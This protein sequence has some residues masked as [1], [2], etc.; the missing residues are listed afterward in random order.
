MGHFR[1]KR[2]RRPSQQRRPTR[3]RPV[4]GPEPRAVEAPVPR[5]HRAAKPLLAGIGKPEPTPF[6]PDPFQT[7]ALQKIS[8]S[9]VLVS[10]PTG[11]G[12]TWIALEAID[13]YLSK[14][15]RAWYATPLKALSN[16][17]YEEFGTR[18][19]PDQVGILTGDRKENPDAP[20]IVG[21]TEILRNQ[22]YDA[23]HAGQDLE[24]DLIILDEAHFLG[25]PD[26]GVVWEEVLIYT[27]SRVRLLLLSATISNADAVARWLTH[28]R[29]CPCEVVLSE[30]R[31]VPLRVLFH[32]PSGELTPFLRGGR[33]FP[34]AADLAKI[35]KKRRNSSAQPLDMNGLVT[36]MREFNLLP[37]IIFLKSRADCD[38][39]L[40]LLQPPPPGPEN[41]G[42]LEAINSVTD[43]YPELQSRPQ[44]D[45]LLARRAGSHHAGQLPAWRLLVEKM[46]SLGYLEVIFSTSTVAAGVNFPARTVVVTQSDRFDGR[47]FVDMTATD[48]HQMTGRAGR[49]GMDNVGFTLVVPGKFMDAELIKR[50]L[51]SSPEPLRSRITV[52][53]SMT[54]NLL[55][56]HKPREVTGLLRKSFAAFHSNP[57]Q[58]RKTQKRLQQEFQ[59]HLILLEELDYL[60]ENGTA[61]YDGQWAAKLRLDHP[62]LIAELI[63]DGAFDDLSPDELAAVIAPFVI[64][65]DRQVYTSR[66]V[67]DVTRPLWKIFRKMIRKLKPLAAF[68]VSRGFDVPPIMFWPAAAAFIW[69]Q[70]V[71]WDYLTEHVGADEGDMAMLILRTIDH[72]RQLV[73]LR[74]EKPQLAYTAEHAMDMLARSPLI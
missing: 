57:A 16:S 6:T 17:K 5:V 41:G 53:F 63:R 32:T 27:P 39:A 49:R 33:V 22:L 31:P 52:N 20:L 73:S 18:Y 24:V 64:D 74:E 10:A 47:S 43:I 25:D 42:F 55:L 45:L 15:A 67:W 13:Q 19:G 1:P 68:L 11:S 62:L 38:K 34:K 54:L 46:M 72:L 35:E 66:V 48:L 8:D 7:E 60:D 69:A 58:A 14:A 36:T 37:A 26:R 9:D 4:A 28:I 56:S 12:K 40:Q 21:T 50:L 59:K 61:T 51:L 70:D 29:G 30:E 2:Q 65:K 23:M 3:K 44:M 71:D